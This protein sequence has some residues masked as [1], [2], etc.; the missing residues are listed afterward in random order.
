MSRLFP[1]SWCME[2]RSSQCWFAWSDHLTM[3]SFACSCVTVHIQCP[4]PSAA[5]SSRQATSWWAGGCRC[6]AMLKGVEPR[7]KDGECH[8]H[9]EQLLAE[10]VWGL[11]C[12]LWFS[13][14]A[15]LTKNTL[16]CY[17]ITSY[18]KY[19]TKNPH[20]MDCIG[21]RV[22]G[23]IFEKS[24]AGSSCW[25]LDSPVFCLERL[26][27]HPTPQ[28]QAYLKLWQVFGSKQHSFL[29]VCLCVRV[30]GQVFC[31]WK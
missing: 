18:F 30:R 12:P 23:E 22:P 21:F 29:T 15:T 13:F 17:T 24:E 11:S 31:G 26:R 25:A 19:K 20:K 7:A 6:W 16:A 5:G 10:Q 1:F 4:G 8:R 28:P 2:W 27:R 14:P 3:F 9:G